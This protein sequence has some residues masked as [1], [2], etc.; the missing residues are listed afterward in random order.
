M[1]SNKTT[2]SRIFSI[3]LGKKG[4]SPLIATVLLIAFAVALGAV[5]MNWGRS[6]V[7][8]TA[9]STQR[10]SQTKVD[11][12]MGVNLEIKEIG[13]NPTLCQNEDDDEI[14]VIFVNRGTKS[15]VGFKTTILGE[16]KIVEYDNNVT[17]KKSSVKKFTFD[18]SFSDN[19]AIDQVVF[20]PKIDVVGTK[21][22]ELCTDAE[23]TSEEI[24][25]C[26]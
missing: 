6:Y 9:E 17:I 11:C 8:D 14:E 22:S 1:S 13:G 7:E 20:T 24:L 5:V 23:L 21:M 10:A 26:D 19:G 4:I 15:L 12:S 16:E 18:Y 25:E 3:R 2:R